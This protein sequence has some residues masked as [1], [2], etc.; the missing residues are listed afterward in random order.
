MTK[1]FN[2][3]PKQQEIVELV[4]KAAD[5][6]GD[7]EFHDLHATLSYGPSV[8]KQAVQY[9]IRYLEQHGFIARKYGHKRECLISPT[10]LA[11]QV[12]RPTSVL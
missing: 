12:F 3:T 4:L 10:L 1:R 6:G 7:L 5:R 9:S 11:Y 8:S 2:N